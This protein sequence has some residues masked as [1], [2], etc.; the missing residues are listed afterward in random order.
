[1]NFRPVDV[2][3]LNRR[4]GTALAAFRACEPFTAIATAL[5]LAQSLPL[6][7]PLAALFIASRYRHINNLIHW[8]SHRSF[9]AAPA[10]NDRFGQLL[11]PA[12]LLRFADYRAEHNSHHQHIGD[13]GKDKDFS[14]LQDFRIGERLGFRGRLKNMARLRL[15]TAYLPKPGFHSGAQ[16]AGTLAYLALFLALPALGWHVAAL[17]LAAG[18]CLFYPI[19]RHLTDLVDHG[20]LYGDAKLQSRNL[21]IGNKLVRWLVFPSNDC[22]HALHHDFPA[23]SPDAQEALHHFLLENA[24]D[25]AAQAHT[26]RQHANAALAASRFSHLQFKQP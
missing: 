14:K 15:V 24:P 9:C 10:A 2:E 18:F 23:I 21:T 1:M 12:I 5:L 11:C 13:Y 17:T 22:F 19:I 3:H 8:A 26:W 7:A 20:G 6:L 25:Y 16:T 4:P